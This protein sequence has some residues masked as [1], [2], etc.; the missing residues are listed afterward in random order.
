MAQPAIPPDTKTPPPPMS[1]VPIPTSLPPSYPSTFPPYLQPQGSGFQQPPAGQPS[2]HPP[3]GGLPLQQLPHGAQSPL[4]TLSPQI[5][6][7]PPYG[8]LPLQQIPGTQS[9]LG[10]LSPQITGHVSPGQQVPMGTLPQQPF[11]ANP[12]QQMPGMNL[13][14]MQAQ[15]GAQYQA[16]QY[17]QCAM[18]NHA[19]QTKYGVLG[20]IGAI[21]V[22]DTSKRRRVTEAHQ[23]LS[24]YILYSKVSN[25][26]HI[27]IVRTAQLDV[28]FAVRRCRGSRKHSH[29]GY[30][31]NISPE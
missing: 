7:Q 5:T 26:A 28:E 10:T 8:S 27:K 4:G 16:S 12:A 15:L 11:G 21:M 17:A 24:N 9:P 30:H 2:Q 31:I 29:L 13:P 20:I 1:A 22:H 6:G 18:G 19:R 25:L 14:M 3:Y 23:H